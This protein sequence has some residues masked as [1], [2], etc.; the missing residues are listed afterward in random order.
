LKNCNKTTSFVTTTTKAPHLR[1]FRNNKFGQL[2]AEE[3]EQLWQVL[4]N[5]RKFAEL[6]NQTLH[7]KPKQRT[8][9][10]AP[11]QAL[12]EKQMECNHNNK[13]TTQRKCC[14]KLEIVPK[15][16]RK[17]PKVHQKF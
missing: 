17:K 11:L 14:K 10:K 4:Q 5:S 2:Q 8:K 12:I 16:K 13:T 6:K 3:E 15:E 1:E 7:K 9:P